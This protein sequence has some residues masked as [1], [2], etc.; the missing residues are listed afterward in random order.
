MSSPHPVATEQPASAARRYWPGIALAAGVT[1][2]ANALSRAPVWPFTNGAGLHSVEPVIIAIVLGLL[3]GNLRPLP[4][5]TRAGV[6]F[7]AKKLLA[8]GIVL[9]GARLDFR[10]LIQV[11]TTGVTFSLCFVIASLL[12]FW[13]LTA[14][15]KLDRQEGLLLGIGTAICGGTAIIAVAPLLR[16][17]DGSVFITVA[18]V[19]LLGVVS[20]VTLPAL[21]LALGLS[22]WQ[23]GLWAGLTIHQTPQVIAAGFAFSPA[24]GQTATVVKLV[25]ICLLAPLALWLGMRR[26]R[27]E[28]GVPA[29]PPSWRRAVSVIPGFVL[30]FL[31]MAAARTF[32]LIPEIGFQWN[33][34]FVGNPFGTQFSLQV[35]FTETAAFL[36][37]MSMAAVGLETNVR[38]IGRKHLRPLAAGA[39]GTVA[40][41]ALGLGLAYLAKNPQ[42]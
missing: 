38:A 33:T 27:S 13:G 31:L 9:L 35:V 41:T 20:M 24:A 21:G 23:F 34:P 2:A 14:L 11:G 3:V 8:L 10:S 6:Q 37:A 42:P 30:G 4:E 29:Q 16:A 22:D 32:G 36:L 1:I 15:L 19:T 25:R 12:L 17:R 28:A 18:I 7:A 26:D 5:R 40:L 39:L